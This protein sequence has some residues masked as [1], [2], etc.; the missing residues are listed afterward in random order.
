[1]PDSSE[2]AEQRLKKSEAEKRAIFIEEVSR[3]AIETFV[4]LKKM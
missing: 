4:C 3:D 1:L 2:A